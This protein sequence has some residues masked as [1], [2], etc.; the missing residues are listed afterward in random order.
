[1][2]GIKKGQT[3]G[4]VKQTALSNRIYFKP[5]LHHEV[6]R[7]P[8][9]LRRSE[10]VLDRNRKVRASPPAAACKGKPWDEILGIV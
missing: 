10:R 6:I 4:H 1:M 3:Y 2:G 8:G 5:S 9:V 7:H